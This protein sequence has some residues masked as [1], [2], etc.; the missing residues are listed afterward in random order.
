[1]KEEAATDK[2]QE[3][4]EAGRR[5]GAWDKDITL[6]TVDFEAR[7]SIT[8]TDFENYSVD[9]DFDRAHDALD[10]MR[11]TARQHFGRWR[12]TRMEAT[13][14]AERALELVNAGQYE[15]ALKEAQRAASLDVSYRPFADALAE[16]RN[17]EESGEVAI[18]V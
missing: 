12:R 8:T 10:R 7:V 16:A 2:V 5:G 18:D 3:A 17:A 6:K 11:E 1:M 14:A 9:A 15:E 4:F 13:Q